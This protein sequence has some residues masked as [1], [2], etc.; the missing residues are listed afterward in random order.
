MQLGKARII[1]VTVAVSEPAL[2]KSALGLLLNE[3]VKSYQFKEPY[4]D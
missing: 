4:I 2:F 3:V 1:A